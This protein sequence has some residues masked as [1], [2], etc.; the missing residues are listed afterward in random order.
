MVPRSHSAAR[1]DKY[2]IDA[3]LCDVCS[4]T[5]IDLSDCCEGPKVGH[6]LCDMQA[7][8][9]CL[10]FCGYGELRESAH[11]LFEDRR[12]PESEQTANHIDASYHR[13]NAT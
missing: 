5:T 1:F 11:V 13:G 9:A 4:E 3:V 12:Q 6:G 8:S 2:S 10:T 7:A